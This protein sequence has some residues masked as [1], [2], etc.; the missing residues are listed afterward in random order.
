MTMNK[1]LLVA[2][3]LGLTGTAYYSYDQLRFGQKTKA[4]FSIGLG[5]QEAEGR[6]PGRRPGAGGQVSEGA[7]P[8]DGQA[9]ERPAFERREFPEGQRPGGGGHG[10]GRGTTLSLEN[11]FHYTVIL[12]FMVM[13]TVLADRSFQMLKRQ[14]R[15]ACRVAIFADRP[16]HF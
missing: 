10:V 14:R 15:L 7:S 1:L 11:V 6:F 16:V 13:L 9:S 5:G 8:P 4:F 12:A 3:L 2:A